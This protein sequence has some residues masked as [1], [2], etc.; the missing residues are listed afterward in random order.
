MMDEKAQE[1]KKP[2]ITANAELITT[3]NEIIPITGQKDT[4]AAKER[5]QYITAEKFGDRYTPELI[6][7]KDV[8]AP[9]GFVDGVRTYLWYH[10]GARWHDN[11][12][13]IYE[14]NGEERIVTPIADREGTIRFTIDQLGESNCFALIRVNVE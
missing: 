7:V 9:D 5:A 3:D 8:S 12:F 4:E 13:I 10:T 1:Y 11:L 2:V 14:L 6:C